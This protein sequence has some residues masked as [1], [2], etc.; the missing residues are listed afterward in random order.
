MVGRYIPTS[1]L[2]QTGF[3]QLYMMGQCLYPSPDTDVLSTHAWVPNPMLRQW[4]HLHGP[5]GFKTSNIDFYATLNVCEILMTML[6]LLLLKTYT[7]LTS[8]VAR[9]CVMLTS[10]VLRAAPAVLFKNQLPSLI[11]H[12]SSDGPMLNFSLIL[13]PQLPSRSETAMQD[14]SFPL[15]QVGSPTRSSSCLISRH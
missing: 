9:L 15:K 1:Q 12:S 8:P 2:I 3:P 4:K 13:E 11:P 7:L 14:N 6:F 10:P 5:A